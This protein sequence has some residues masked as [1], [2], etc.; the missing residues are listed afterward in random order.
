[1]V[2]QDW[3]Y[4]NLGEKSD[5]NGFSAQDSSLAQQMMAA[6]YTRCMRRSLKRF[7][8]MNSNNDFLNNHNND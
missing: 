1:M 2:S 6:I 8:R 3:R 5:M 7:S 4:F